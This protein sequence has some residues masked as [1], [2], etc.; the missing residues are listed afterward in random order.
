LDRS[1]YAGLSVSALSAGTGRAQQSK[2]RL[3]F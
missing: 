2:W 3:C 1:Q